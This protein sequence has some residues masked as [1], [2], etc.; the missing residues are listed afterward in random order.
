MDIYG[1]ENY[2]ER[3]QFAYTLRGIPKLYALS[4]RVGV[5]ESALSRWFRSEPISM[6]NFAK[7]CV[8]LNVNADWLLFGRGHYTLPVT[9]EI[10]HRRLLADAIERMADTD[11]R[12]LAKFLDEVIAP[13]P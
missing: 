10:P 2:G 4:H 5:T 13:A 11:V 7:L 8:A 3:L 9:H 12:N 6:A 1:I